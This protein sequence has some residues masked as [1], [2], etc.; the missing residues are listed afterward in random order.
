MLNQILPAFKSSLLNIK[1][2]FNIVPTHRYPISGMI[3]WDSMAKE[4][5]WCDFYEFQ[6]RS[7][8]DA[9]KLVGYFVADDCEAA[10]KGKRG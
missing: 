10:M 3:H 5:N 2:I 1:Y 9:Q 6:S 4:A 7:D 8:E